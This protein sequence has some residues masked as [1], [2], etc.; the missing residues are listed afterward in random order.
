MH[1]ALL[2]Y[3]NS[4]IAQA[5]L[6]LCVPISRIWDIVHANDGGCIDVSEFMITSAAINVATDIVL[7][8]FPLPLLRLFKF[9][10]RQRSTFTI[11]GSVSNH[12]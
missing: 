7:L 8:M 3:A 2:P 1:S 10:R 5:Q 9:N 11:A 6:F 12:S 4:R